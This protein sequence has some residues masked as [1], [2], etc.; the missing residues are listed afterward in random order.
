MLKCSIANRKIKGIKSKFKFRK[1]MKN[2]SMQKDTHAFFFAAASEVCIVR[3]MQ[4]YILQN[5][6]PV[7]FHFSC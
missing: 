6:L 2:E 1:Y 5:Y 7:V 4:I 3:T